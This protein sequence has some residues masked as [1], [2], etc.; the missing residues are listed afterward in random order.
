MRE[1]LKHFI[2]YSIMFFIILI[3]S[4]SLFLITIIGFMILVNSLIQLTLF[5]A[6]TA[7]TLPVL[8]LAIPVTILELRKKDK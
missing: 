5:E 8:L 7:L 6:I 2:K 1:F 3:S 4:V